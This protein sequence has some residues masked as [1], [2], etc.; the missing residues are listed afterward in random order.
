M[1]VLQMLMMRYGGL[2][3]SG[4]HVAVPDRGD[5]VPPQPLPP[6]YAK[7]Q[8]A[9]AVDLRKFATPVGD[10]GQT[11][12]CSAY[13]WTHALE[14]SDGILGKPPAKLSVN[15]TMLSFQ[16]MQGDADGYAWAYKGGDGTVGG[17]E[18]G[19]AL[20]QD[21]TC[22]QE[23]WPDDA[24]RPLAPDA[25]LARDAAL[26]KLPGRP[27]PIAIDDLK[28]VLSAGCP[29]HV[30]MNTGSAFSEVGRD[31]VFNAAEP[32]SGQHGRHAMLITGYTGNFFTV[33]NSWG[34]NWGDKGYSY[35]PKK[36]LAESDAEFVAVLL[37][38]QPAS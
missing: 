16:K 26:H 20:A 10:Q 6:E 2:D 21:G 34:E 19:A 8:E 28:K 23:L 27:H 1:A 12:R 17:P 9:D 24:Q 4:L 38:L 3:L 36:V 7:V 18:P 13:A 11:S 14:L 32:A 15:Y 5:R 35:V 31:G 37:P 22:R 29:V 30:A 25:G 33:K